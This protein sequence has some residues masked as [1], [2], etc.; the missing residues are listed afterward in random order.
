MH[1][2]YLSYAHSPNVA[3]ADM[4]KISRGHVGVPRA[5][6]HRLQAVVDNFSVL[7]M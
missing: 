1:M 6:L 5:Q 7:C 3:S 2:L 4:Q